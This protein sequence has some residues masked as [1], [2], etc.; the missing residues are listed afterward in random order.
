MFKD[1]QLVAEASPIVSVM[2]DA[3]EAAASWEDVPVFDDPL[4]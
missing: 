1:E 2:R 3:M 4:Y